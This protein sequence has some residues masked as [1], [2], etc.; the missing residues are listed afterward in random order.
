MLKERDSFRCRKCLG[1][2]QD[3]SDEIEKVK[4][5]TVGADRIEAA[6]RFCYLGDVIDE[7]ERLTRQ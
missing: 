4:D 5:I 7:K 2:V 1:Q 3:D 6:D